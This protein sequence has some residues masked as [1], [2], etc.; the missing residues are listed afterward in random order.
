MI[1]Y[2]VE[3]RH[4]RRRT[5]RA[6]FAALTM[7]ALIVASA[8]L[9]TATADGPDATSR[10]SDSDAKAL[11]LRAHA[12]AAAV[13][14]LPQFYYRVQSGNGDVETMLDIE[15]CSL[16]LLTKALDEPI[17]QDR[18]FQSGQTLAWSNG[19]VVWSNYGRKFKNETQQSNG[20]KYRQDRVWTIGDA[21]ERSESDGRPARFVFVPK[22]ESLWEGRLNQLGWFR[23]TPHQFWW[24]KGSSHDYQDTVSVISP[25]LAAYQFVDSERFDGELC[26]VVE[27]PTRAERLWIGRE[28][29]RLRGVLV[30]MFRGAMPAEPFYATE[31]VEKMAGRP[32]AS[33]QEYQEWVEKLTGRQKIEL[34][35][36]WNEMYFEQF[37][38][39]ELMRFRDYREVAPGVWV[40]FR[41]DRVFTHPAGNGQKRRK[42]IHL[43]AAVQE[44]R[45]DVDLT[46]SV[47]KLRPSDGDPVQDQRFGAVINYPFRRERTEHELLVLADEAD[48]V[49]EKNAPLP[50]QQVLARAEHKYANAMRLVA[51]VTWRPQLESNLRRKV[52]LIN[53]L[54]GLTDDQ[55]QKLELAGRG[56]I[57]RH[58]DRVTELGTQYELVKNDPGKL[59][60]LSDKALL[61]RR[62]L[63]NFSNDDAL[64]VKVLDK[65]LTPEQITRY[66]PLRE[67]IRAGGRARMDERDSGPALAIMLNETGI[68]DGGLAALKDLPYVQYLSVA[69]TKVSDAGL[70]HFKG[71]ASLEQL[72]L[73]DTQVSDAGLVHL[74]GLTRLNTVSLENT[75]VTS[76]GVACLKRLTALRDLNLANTR[77][78]DAALADLR[79][80]TNLERLRLDGTQTTDA[81]MVDLAELK[82]LWLLGLNNT[83]VTDTGLEPLRRLPRLEELGLAATPVTDA[84][85]TKLRQASPRLRIYR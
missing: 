31:V 21:F 47:E 85:V 55:K 12:E 5:A 61:I 2:R 48:R 73:G 13:D 72:D 8:E 9:E 49:P 62:S 78:N 20:D 68:T 43:W 45:T 4:T 15:D 81:G 14:K 53:T 60:D 27:S 25:E 23:V 37:G 71:L 58:I 17:S 19:L 51:A 7:L 76:A 10:L 42:Y 24:A 38:P 50:R 54:C 64:L 69:R 39:N 70:A 65:I 35:I 3:Q 30:F 11:A 26:D 75:P 6:L 18:W 63:L 84:G 44:V 46:D 36:A 82:K 41:E 66:Q 59:T 40:P 22:P 33:Q 67:I 77:V 74:E 32:I 80:L 56:D 34:S 29:Q 1:R 16:P 79:E 28:S 57:K 52:A 83:R